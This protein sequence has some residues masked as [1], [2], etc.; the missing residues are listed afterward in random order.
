MYMINTRSRAHSYIKSEGFTLIELLVAIAVSAVVLLAIGQFFISTNRTNTVQEK[1]AG[2]QQDIRGAMELMTRDIRMAGLDP[3]G[4]ATCAGFV[5]NGSGDDTDA[6]SV[7]IRYDFNGDGDC[8]DPE[9]VDVCYSF[10]STTN[11]TLEFRDGAGNTFE[12]LTQTGI[13]DVSESSISYTL[14]D[15]STTSNPTDLDDI[16]AVTIKICGHITD[17]YSS[18]FPNTYC[19]TNT[20]KARNM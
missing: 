5:D 17:A 19:F 18:D 13:I 15:G 14:S 20:I 8:S 10:D 12:P 4:D 1:V 3:S 9:D 2:V 11:G 16:R 7:A 6:D